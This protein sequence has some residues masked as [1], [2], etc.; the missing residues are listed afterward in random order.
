MAAERWTVREGCVF[1][2]S[3]VPPAASEAGDARTMVEVEER[4]NSGGVCARAQI[5]ANASLARFTNFSWST[6]PPAPS[7]PPSLFKNGHF[8][9]PLVGRSCYLRV[10][11]PAKWVFEFHRSITATPGEPSVI[12]PPSDIRITNIA[13]GEELADESGRTTI[14]L[15]YRR[16]GA[17]EPDSED[18]EDDEEKENDNSDLSTTVLCSLTP[19]KVCS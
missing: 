17:D 14:K 16:P 6:T 7:S 10:V 19:G 18:E 12:S 4:S 5:S 2:V 3:I 9:R 8:C 11:S 1:V 13:L 15:V